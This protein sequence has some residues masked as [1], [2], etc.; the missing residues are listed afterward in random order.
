MWYELDGYAYTDSAFTGDLHVASIAKIS[1][2]ATLAESP[3]CAGM[4]NALRRGRALT[5]LELARAAGVTPQIAKDHL[6]RIDETGL[7]GVLQHRRRDYYRLASPAVVQ[8]VERILPDAATWDPARISVG[9][10]DKTMRAGRTCY[11]HLAGG[12]GIALAD[13]LVE[14]D[15]VE[16]SEGSG[17]VTNA[18]VKFLNGIGI[19]IEALMASRRKASK[20]ALCRPCLDWSERRPHIAGTVGDAL[21]THSFTEGWIRRVEGT[22]SVTVTS[23]GRRVYGDELGMELD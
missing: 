20:R 19:D 15:Y 1:A 16:F 4:L 12:V 14:A 17:A 23:K 2:L 18:G 22:R 9:P 8:I 11:N 5:A 7:L 3:V 21:C 10:R 6:A 13:A